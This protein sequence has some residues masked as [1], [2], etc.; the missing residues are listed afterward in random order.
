MADSIPDHYLQR[1]IILP[2]EPRQNVSR[3]CQMSPAGQ[4]CPPYTHTCHKQDPQGYK[5]PATF[6]PSQKGS[7]CWQRWAARAP[8][9]RGWGR[10]QEK[11][12]AMGTSTEVIC[13]SSSPLAAPHFYRGGPPSFLT[14][15]VNPTQ[16]ST[17]APCHHQH[18]GTFLHLPGLGTVPGTNYVLN[19]HLLHKGMSP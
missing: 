19:K 16:A 11:A 2:Q 9:S 17:T 18:C 7:Q 12:Y 13:H 3:Q 10:S 15:P 6:L 8:G 4:K 1:L 14:S 5:W